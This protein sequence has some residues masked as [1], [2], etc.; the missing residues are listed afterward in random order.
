MYSTGC[1]RIFKMTVLSAATR[2]AR[3]LALMGGTFD[4]IHLGHLLVAEFVAEHLELEKVVFVPNR[5]PPLHDSKRP[6]PPTR[7]L[8]MVQLAIA[9]NPRFEACA[10]EL[11]REGPS[12]SIDTI[13]T[14]RQELS[15]QAELY[16]I[17][18][19]DELLLLPK[20]REPAAILRE[21]R[22]VGV[23]RPG[24]DLSTLET[25][26]GAEWTALIELVKAPQIEISS[27]EI[28]RRVAAGLSIRYMTPQP[29]I[30]YI[31]AHKLYT[32]NPDGAAQVRG[33]SL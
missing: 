15:P 22:V 13:R 26:L 27:S 5:I 33:A 10:V 30:E 4:P 14:V 17:V 1:G 31:Y 25:V 7:R 6:A 11:Q 19:A 32:E 23:T 9:D 2:Q 24:S 12:Y 16:L 18:G 20:W 3:R 21:S 28:R 8:E 29:V